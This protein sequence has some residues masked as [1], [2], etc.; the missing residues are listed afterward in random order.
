MIK[1][2]TPED[3]PLFPELKTLTYTKADKSQK[4]IFSSNENL[5]FLV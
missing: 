5:L 2:I 1:K 4:N 3:L